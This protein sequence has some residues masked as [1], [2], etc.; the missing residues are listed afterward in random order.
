MKFRR[1]ATPRR[2]VRGG[3]TDARRAV[4]V[5]LQDHREP[6][7]RQGEHPQEGR[8]GVLRRRR[9]GHHA[10]GPDRKQL[11]YIRTHLLFLGSK[12][13]V[14]N[15][16][17]AS[18]QGGRQGGRRPRRFVVAKPYKSSEEAAARGTIAVQ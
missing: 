10:G 6:E 3:G 14:L 4:D 15:E 1:N 7:A 18:R 16:E 12:A 17:A 5:H 13:H 9:R 8:R 2:Q 11:N